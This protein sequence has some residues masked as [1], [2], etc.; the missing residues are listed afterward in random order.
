MLK[1]L[2]IIYLLYSSMRLLYESI[3]TYYIIINSEDKFK[4]LKSPII[5]FVNC[6]TFISIIYFILE[7]RWLYSGSYTE[8]EDVD[9]YLWSFLEGLILFVFSNICTLLRTLI[10]TV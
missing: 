3:Y 10:R 6:M 1:L 9:E 7:F 8:L 4:K 5:K 2:I